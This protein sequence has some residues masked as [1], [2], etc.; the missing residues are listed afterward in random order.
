MF[1][2]GTLFS[3]TAFAAPKGYWFDRWISF[4]E[5]AKALSESEFNN[6]SLQFPIP[7]APVLLVA[8][9]VRVCTS[10]V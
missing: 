2:V 6:P 10:G 5:L 4:G 3:A 8:G 9:Y 7:D 1:V